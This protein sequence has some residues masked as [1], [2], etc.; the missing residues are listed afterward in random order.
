MIKTKNIER[1]V[2][3]S[4]NRI[5]PRMEEILRPQIRKVRLGWEQ[6]SSRLHRNFP[7]LLMLQLNATQIQ[8]SNKDH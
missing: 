3:R 6:L 4:L 5:L 8:H 1:E 2:H 7:V